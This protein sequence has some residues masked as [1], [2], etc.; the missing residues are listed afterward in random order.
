MDTR[1]WGRYSLSM[2]TAEETAAFVQAHTALMA[3][4]GCPEIRLHI[5]SAM[6]SLWQASERFLPGAQVPPPYWGLAWAGS[7]ALARHIIE[8]RWLVRGR[9]VLDYAAGSGI[10]GIAAAMVG[11]ATVE[12]YDADLLAQAVVSLNAK[13]NDVSIH[14]IADDPLAVEV[15]TTPWEVVL[16]GDAGYEPTTAER[17]MPWLRALAG[18]GALVLV[19]DPGGTYAAMKGMVHL[20]DYTLPTTSDPDDQNTRDA[21]IYRIAA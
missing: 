15:K 18:K 21:A 9:K 7:Q 13:A 20:A 19:A 3:P 4:P 11:A 12:A 1:L 10:A 16:V 6:S 5:A 17:C 2:P 8:N 14:L